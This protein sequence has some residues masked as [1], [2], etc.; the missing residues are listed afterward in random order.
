M[1]PKIFSRRVMKMGREPEHS[2]MVT[3]PKRICEKLQIE[4]GT[5]LYFKLE[6]CK[7]VVSKDS[8][9]LDNDDINNND[10]TT[11]VEFIKQTK[12]ENQE[13]KK[14]EKDIIVDGVSLAELQ[15]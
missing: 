10:D 14:G 9:Y 1:I 12:E 3:I 11:L 6:D 8:K 5:K 7:F 15:Y 2:L 13:D 4:K